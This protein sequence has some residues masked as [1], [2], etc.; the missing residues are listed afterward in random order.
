[1]QALLFSAIAGIFGFGLGGTASAVLLKR[2]SENATNLIMSF[3][4]GIMV[5]IGCFSLIPEA[6][7]LSGVWVS[8]GGI[9]IGVLVII[10]L[11]KLI[12]KVT[13]ASRG[14]IVSDQKRILRAGIYV[15]AAISLHTI[16]EGIAI[17]ASSSHSLQL[18]AVLAVMIALHHIPEGMAIAA[19]LL[20]GGMG[21][22]K[23]VCLTALT[24][25]PALLGGFI[26]MAIGNISDLIVAV[27][28]SAA[29]G[30]MLF[31][32]FA[33]VIPQSLAK[34]KKLKSPVMIMLGFLVGLIISQVLETA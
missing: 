4:S 34:S 11:N 33:E 27:A 14:D 23:V 28:L 25:A 6:I 16:P 15:L 2:P 12:D 8:A 3:A 21:R 10:A 18:G 22:G 9:V 5:S 31:V 29:G 20:A 30:A 24:G 19:P 26:G 1:M 7:A 17:G 32:M 13:E